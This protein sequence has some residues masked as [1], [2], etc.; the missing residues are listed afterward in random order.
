MAKKSRNKGDQTNVEYE[1][2]YG[3]PPIKHQF[4]K[5]QSGNPRG[6][7]RPSNN[8]F[9]LISE[10]LQTKIII[11]ENGQRSR[12]TKLEAMVKQM[13][14]QAV[15]GSP[16]AQK[17]ILD[18]LPQIE[19]ELAVNS[20]ESP[21]TFQVIAKALNELAALKAPKKGDG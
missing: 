19:Q 2:G 18:L 11:N 7:P 6:R 17:F 4:Q 1:V 14:V 12:I 13:I 8:P 15:Q 3:K 21:E 5:G 16:R 10:E 9:K 20:P